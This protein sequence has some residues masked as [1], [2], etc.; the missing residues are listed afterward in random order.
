MNLEYM[1]VS[2]F[3]LYYRR[4][5]TFTQ[6]SI[7]FRC[8]C[9]CTSLSVVPFLIGQYN[10]EWHHVG[11]YIII[12][13]TVLSVL[14]E[15]TQFLQEQY[16]LTGVIFLTFYL[17]LCNLNRKDNEAIF[18]TTPVTKHSGVFRWCETPTTSVQEGLALWHTPLYRKWTRPCLQGLIRWMAV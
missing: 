6:Y 10:D 2:F 3:E 5:W 18:V 11:L 8:T 9:I 17:Y 16:F 1:K 15:P 14:L 4:K 13:H 7:F 12:H